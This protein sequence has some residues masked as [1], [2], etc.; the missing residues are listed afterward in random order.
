MKVEMKHLQD[1]SRER[2]LKMKRLQDLSKIN[3]KSSLKQTRQLLLQK[4]ALRQ[5]KEE[6]EVLKLQLLNCQR[7][8]S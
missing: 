3:N 2:D 8:Q 5:A 1:R 6:I 4:E 7:G